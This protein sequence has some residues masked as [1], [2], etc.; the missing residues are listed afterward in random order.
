M[1]E[2][3]KKYI[4]LGLIILAETSFILYF[5]FGPN[6]KMQA[7]SKSTK[8]ALSA[9]DVINKV[10]NLEQKLELVEPVQEKSGLYM[11]YGKMGTT[12]LPN[13]FFIT[14]DGKYLFLEAIPLEEAKK[15]AEQR[16]DISSITLIRQP[17]IGSENAPVKIVEFLDFTCAY[18]KKFSQEVFPKIKQE[19]VDKGKVQFIFKN[20]PLNTVSQKLALA[21]E[22]AFDQGKFWEFYE[23]IYSQ[24]SASL[25]DEQIKSLVQS[26]GIDQKKFNEC[27]D[28]QKYLQEIENDFQEGVAVGVNGT[29]AFFVNKK[30]VPGFKSFDDFKT[31]IENELNKK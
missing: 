6:I 11:F 14:K 29:P 31:I 27:F 3:E 21:G 25:S 26:I 23:L 17:T 4:I 28:S 15:M 24:P 22:C 19:Y 20:F 5:I 7:G 18:C 16:K 9:I 12:T 30:S 2:K 1:N 10:F 8:L 13:P